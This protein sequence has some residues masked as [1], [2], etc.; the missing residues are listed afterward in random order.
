MAIEWD[1]PMSIKLCELIESHPIIWDKHH[2]GYKNS[3]AKYDVFKA[4]SNT[5][6]TDNVIEVKEKWNKLKA[7]FFREKKKEE[8]Q[9][10]G[11]AACE[12]YFSKWFLMNVLQYLSPTMDIDSTIT[13]SQVEVRIVI[14]ICYAA[15]MYVFSNVVLMLCVYHL[16]TGNWNEPNNAQNNVEDEIIEVRAEDVDPD[17]EAIAADEEQER[18]TERELQGEVRESSRVRFTAKHRKR[19]AEEAAL[20]VAVTSLAK[21][22]AT[23][24]GNE[25]AC[26]NKDEQ[27]VFGELVARKIRKLK[28]VS[29]L[30]AEHEINNTLFQLEV[31]DAGLVIENVSQIS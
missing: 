7:Q 8:K 21:S 10:S 27:D 20:S 6:G 14:T 13:S 2:E 9:K 3:V 26:N 22:L 11:T 19:A 24:S 1:Q 31:R 17:I 29:Q 25:N 30:E 12:R 4:I 16:Q 18:L 28:P 15:C 23:T 5:L